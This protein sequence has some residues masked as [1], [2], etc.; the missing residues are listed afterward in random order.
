MALR[1]I[2]NCGYQGL[3]IGLTTGKYKNYFEF[4]LIPAGAVALL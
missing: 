3:S 4:K 1:I 2:V